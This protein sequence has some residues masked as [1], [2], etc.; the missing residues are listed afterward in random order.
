MPQVLHLL[1]KVINLPTPTSELMSDFINQRCATNMCIFIVTKA[2]HSTYMYC[3]IFAI[4]A[5]QGL[6]RIYEFATLSCQGK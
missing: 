6:L 2:Q 5:L 3:F 4:S 1:K